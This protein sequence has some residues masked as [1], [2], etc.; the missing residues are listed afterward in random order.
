MSENQTLEMQILAKSEEAIKSLDKLISKLTG[1][2][3]TVNNVDKT[4]NKG[5]VK[6]VTNNINQ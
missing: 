5:T 2:E 1:V 4:I 3:K 6:A